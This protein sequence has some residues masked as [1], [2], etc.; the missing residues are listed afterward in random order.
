MLSLDY[1]L[2]ERIK[3]SDLKAFDE[4]YRRYLKPIYGYIYKRV[5]HREDAQDITQDVFTRVFRHI[6]DFRRH[7]LSH[8]FILLL[9]MRSQGF[10][11]SEVN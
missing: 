11:E 10:S 5:N 4:L 6:K 1:Y 2:I 8:G 7:L 3:Q 9:K